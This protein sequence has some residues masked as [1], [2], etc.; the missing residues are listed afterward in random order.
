MRGGVSPHSPS[1]RL[2][3][4]AREQDRTAIC[5]I[6]TETSL[7][8]RGAVVQRGLIEMNREPHTSLLLSRRGRCSLSQSEDVET[9]HPI[10]A[11]R[12]AIRPSSTYYLEQGTRVWGA[13]DKLIRQ[14][15]SCSQT[16]RPCRIKT[17]AP[18][19][20]DHSIRF[21]RRT[22]GPATL[23]TMTRPQKLDEVQILLLYR[24]WTLRKWIRWD[25]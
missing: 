3:C 1:Y 20:R 14:Q 11:R 7:R 17:W 9:W 8:H 6:D 10:S 23:M 5:L 18:V 19:L 24:A 22:P 16:A 21:M 15:E 12:Q 4:T 25:W 13:V 2:G